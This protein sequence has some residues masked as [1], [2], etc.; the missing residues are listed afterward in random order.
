MFNRWPRLGFSDL[1]D[2]FAAARAEGRAVFMP[3]LTAGL[4]TIETSVERFVAMADAGA[5]AFEVG[6]PYADPLMD[7]PTVQEASEL[8]RERGMTMSIGLDLVR[9]V[10]ALTGKPVIVMTY[11]NPVLTMGVDGFMQAVSEAGAAGVI[12]ADLPFEESEPFS[13]SAG[14]HDVG[15]ALFVAPTT[16]EERV[17]AIA[18]SQ[19]AFIYGVAE[20]GVTGERADGSGHI[21]GL[22]RLVR[23]ISQVPIVL[24]VGISTPD[25]AAKA[26]ELADGV[27]V[28]SAIVRI[29]LE[30]PDD[31]DIF[32]T[33]VSSLA[34]AVHG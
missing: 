14:E 33:T 12:I 7:G 23:S 26:G 5:D 19:P 32:T 27:I 25:Q 29:V 4:P 2:T 8:S 28:G 6:I 10:A 13:K 31:L 18:A 16:P 22:I 3:F 9:Q 1:Q 17:R 30:Q 24:G 11:V 20:M 15:L 21:E 34:K